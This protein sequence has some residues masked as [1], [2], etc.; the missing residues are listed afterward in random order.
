MP[1]LSPTAKS[2]LSEFA[3]SRDE[4][5]FRRVVVEMGALDKVERDGIHAR[6]V[7]CRDE[8]RYHAILAALEAG[9]F[10]PS[11]RALCLIPL[12]T[13]SVS[14]RRSP[15]NSAAASAVWA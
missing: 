15:S 1:T 10:E 13:I 3:L 14:V 5:A 12:T 9:N 8:G 6:G 4:P 7:G 2:A 11:R